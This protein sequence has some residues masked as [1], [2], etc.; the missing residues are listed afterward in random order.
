MANLTD[1][2]QFGDCRSLSA[3]L[4]VADKNKFY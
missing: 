4:P 3:E 1:D 2:G